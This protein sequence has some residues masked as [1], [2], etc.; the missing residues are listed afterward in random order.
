MAI[1]CQSTNWSE[2]QP[3]V[4]K[5]NDQLRPRPTS[6]QRIS[7]WASQP[8]SQH[9]KIRGKP[10]AI[11][12]PIKTTNLIL[13]AKSIRNYWWNNV[14]VADATTKLTQSTDNQQSKCTESILIDDWKQ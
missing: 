3:V 1:K 13:V 6:E 8:I 14:A 12:W 4:A 2:Y 11:T 7:S 10:D 5:F 9:P